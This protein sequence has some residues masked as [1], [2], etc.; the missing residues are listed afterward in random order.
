MDIRKACFNETPKGAI[1]ANP[2]R[3]L[4]LPQAYAAR[5]RCFA[6]ENNNE[7]LLWGETYSQK[8]EDLGFVRSVC[9][10]CVSIPK[11]KGLRIVVHGDDVAIIGVHANAAKVREHVF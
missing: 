11:M 6:Y 9:P 2:P 3:K 7:D 1:H 5:P 4:G 10:P 8:L